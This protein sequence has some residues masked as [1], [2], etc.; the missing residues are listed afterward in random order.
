M[1]PS[2]PTS[3]PLIISI[4]D[5]ANCVCISKAEVYRKIKAG[6]FPLPVRLTE[7][8]R[9]IRVADLNAWVDKLTSVLPDKAD[10]FKAD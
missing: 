1:N 8:R 9:G 3:S 2:K 6:Q 10:H 4:S 7:K 5:A